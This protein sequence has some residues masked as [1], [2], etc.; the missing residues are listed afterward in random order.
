MSSSK[1]SRL[2]DILD[3]VAMLAKTCHVWREANIF[4][5]GSSALWTLGQGL[6]EDWTPE[7]KTGLNATILSL[8]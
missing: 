3:E 4:T 7:T 1:L 8:R 2:E 5:G 6:G